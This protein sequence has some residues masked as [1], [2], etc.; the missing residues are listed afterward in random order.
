MIPMWMTFIMCGV[1][2]SIGNTYFLEQANN[3]N[4]KVGKLKVPL[5]IFKFFYDL[6]K[7]QFPKLYDKE[8]KK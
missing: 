2:L 7:E 6:V 3:M 1:V 5:P 8:L 4:R